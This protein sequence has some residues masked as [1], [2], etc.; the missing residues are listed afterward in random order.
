MNKLSLMFSTFDRASES[1][2]PPFAAPHAGVAIRGF[3]DAI[4]NVQRNTDISNHPDD[5][6]L[7]EIGTFDNETGRLEPHIEGKKLLVQGKQVALQLRSQRESDNS[8]N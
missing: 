7:F 1:F 8:F 5:Y 3:S 2:S 6:D 4:G